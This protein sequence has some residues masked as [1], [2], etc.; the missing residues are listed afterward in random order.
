MK[1]QLKQKSNFLVH[2][3]Q[4]NSEGIRRTVSGVVDRNWLRIG[5]SS[6]GPKQKFVKKLGN[7]IAT[8]R[9]QKN[10]DHM[11]KINKDSDV[12]E[13]FFSSLSDL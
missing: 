4:A 9:A 12:R 6:V 13:L 8:G 3:K 5:I 2:D 1:N 11:I 10:P 7:T